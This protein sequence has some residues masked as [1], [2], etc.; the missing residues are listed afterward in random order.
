MPTRHPSI[1]PSDAHTPIFSTDHPPDKQALD[2][3]QIL[4]Q[5]LRPSRFLPIS[6]ASSSSATSPPA[7]APATST[8]TSNS[9]AVQRAD[10]GSGEGT[11]RARALDGRSTFPQVWSRMAMGTGTAM[12]R[13]TVRRCCRASW[14]FWFRQQRAP[15]NKIVSYEDGSKRVAAFSSIEYLWALTTHLA[16]PSVLVPSLRLPPLPRRRAAP[17][18]GGPAE[19]NWGQEALEGA[20]GERWGDNDAAEG[21]NSTSGEDAGDTDAPEICECTIGVRQSEGIIS[22]WNRVDDARVRGLETPLA[23]RSASPRGR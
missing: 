13:R 6:A 23:R 4:L 16:P 5:P 22:L 17:R 7:A 8:S 12:R 9:T 18:V 14:V 3:Q 10:S 21:K 20:H 19:Y 15:G 11:G 1:T 2:E